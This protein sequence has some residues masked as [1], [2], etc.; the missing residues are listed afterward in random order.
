MKTTTFSLTN[1]TDTDLT[2]L[3]ATCTSEMERRKQVRKERRDKWIKETIC[4]YLCEPNASFARIGETTVVAV[5]SRYSGLLMGKATPLREMHSIR[6]LVLPLPMPRL[7]ASAFLI[8]SKGHCPPWEDIARAR[9][10]KVLTNQNLYDIISIQ[11]RE[12]WQP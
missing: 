10:K 2:N 3:I 11:L 12:R 1:L 4:A 5:Y 6:M 7:T 9:F 8:T